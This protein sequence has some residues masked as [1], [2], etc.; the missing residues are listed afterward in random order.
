M[1]E[2]FAKSSKRGLLSYVELGMEI[3]REF[4][5][6]KYQITIDDKTWE[7]HAALI[8]VGNSSQWGNGAKIAP[9]ADSSDGQLDVT[10]A[11]MFTS[12]EMP[13][14]ACLLMTGYLD[15]SHRIHCHRGKNIRISRKSG[16]PAHADGDWFEAG[17][18][19]DICVIP[20]ALNVL[21]PKN[22]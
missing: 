20:G 12:I 15:I 4:Q 10:I 2:K 3:W 8:T 13:A 11:D 18:E 17:T 22:D 19:I 9:L 5:P 21:V 16:G 6:E 1:S 14:L 7:N